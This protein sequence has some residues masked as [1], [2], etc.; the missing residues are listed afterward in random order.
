M[1]A[2]LA[3]KP[4]VIFI[5]GFPFN[6]S[7]WTLQLEALK[8]YYHLI[9]YDLRGFGDSEEGTDGFAVENYSENLIQF[10]DALY[11]EKA[12]VCG[13]GLGGN[14]ALN[15][16]ER[17]SQRIE[18][19]VLSSTQTK[20]ESSEAKESRINAIA[21]IQA[22]DFETFIED[23][24]KSVFA[25]ISFTTKREEIAEIKNLIKNNAV[26]VSVKMLQA[27][28]ERKD[29]TSMLAEIKVPVLIM[30]GK[31]DI[32]TPPLQAE[33]LH[34]NL[35]DSVIELMDYAGH[36]P[37]LE[38]PLEFN[39]HL[40]KFLDKTTARSRLPHFDRSEKKSA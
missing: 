10:M 3:S 19:L 15:A 20:S 17:F 25:Y 32:L 36:L 1:E 26:A 8:E 39:R 7:I 4:T 11:I 35:S 12:I 28:N 16:A 24:V 33:I 2:G 40:K 13:H 31:K 38:N 27:L 9:A 5:H 34:E 29:S 37:N 6:K 30:V 14:I 18:A 23:T 22:G 21:Q